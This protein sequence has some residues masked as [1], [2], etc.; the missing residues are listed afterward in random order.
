MLPLE[1]NYNIG[2]FKITPWRL[3]ILSCSLPTIIA[4]IS[5][6][7]CPESPKYL[8]VQ[9]RH[10]EALEILKLGYTINTKSPKENYPVSKII[11]TENSSSNLKDVNTIQDAFKMI[12]DQTIPLFRKKHVWYTINISI[13]Q[14]VIYCLAHGLFMW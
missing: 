8:L 3:Y 11:F 6:Q 13:H 10:D 4:L 7:F 12:W 14:F 1:L 5:L 2:N 9:G